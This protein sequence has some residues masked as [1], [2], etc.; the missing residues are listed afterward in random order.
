[1]SCTMPPDRTQA[2][3]TR[4]T[5][6]THTTHTLRNSMNSWTPCGIG[7]NLCTHQTCSS[8]PGNGIGESG[9]RTYLNVPGPMSFGSTSPLTTRRQHSFDSCRQRARFSVSTCTTAT[10]VGGGP[11]RPGRSIGS[12]SQRP[13]RRTSRSLCLMSIGVLTTVRRGATTAKWSPTRTSSSP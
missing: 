4:T 2:S 5:H 13:F 10:V 9:P 7:H 12:S 6:T 11:T 8:K 3:W 1:M